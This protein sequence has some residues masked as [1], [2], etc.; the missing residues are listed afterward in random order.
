MNSIYNLNYIM[1]FILIIYMLIYFK[2][3]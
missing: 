3:I 1:I 2:F